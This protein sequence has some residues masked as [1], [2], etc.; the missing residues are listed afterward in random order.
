MLAVL[1]RHSSG[2]FLQAKGDYSDRVHSDQMVL[3]MVRQEAGPHEMRL[4][5]Q[6]RVGKLL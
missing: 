2:I 1:N 3:M 6:L 4:V 5:V